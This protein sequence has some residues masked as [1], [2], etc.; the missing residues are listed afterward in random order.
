[1]GQRVITIDELHQFEQYLRQEERSAGTIENYRRNMEELAGWLSGQEV[2]K[3]Q[4]L[5]WKEELQAKHLKPTTINVKLAAVSCF[6]RYMGWQDCQVRFLRVQRRVFRERDRELTRVEYNKLLATACQKG[7]SRLALLLETICATGV[8]VS[9]VQY[10]TV[11]AAKRGR[12]EVKMKGKIRTILLPNKL[13]RKLLK[14]A[15]KEN[16][17]SGQIFLT[18]NGT[19]LSRKQIWAEMKALCKAADVASGKVFPH[20]LRHLFATV[21]YRVCHDIVKLADVL[22]HSRIETTRIY[23]VTTGF[24]YARQLEQLGLV[25]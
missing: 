14:Y 19:V 12:A 22:G 9:E 3:E 25:S 15:Q 17:V 18:R 5:A 10:I 7:K 11:E 21:F 20:N 4:L 24:E 6:L 2:T 13:C 23:L 16:A 8:R 1:M